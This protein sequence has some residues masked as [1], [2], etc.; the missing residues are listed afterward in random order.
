[1]KQNCKIEVTKLKSDIPNTGQLKY[2]D[3]V[4]PLKTIKKKNK[5]KLA[6][7]S[8]FAVALTL[9]LTVFCLSNFKGFSKLFPDPNFK[10][11]EIGPVD[12]NHVLNEV[13]RI[14]TDKW[15][16]SDE[17][18]VSDIHFTLEMDGF[19]NNFIGGGGSVM[20]LYDPKTHS[21]FEIHIA[22]FVNKNKLLIQVSKY[23]IDNTLIYMNKTTL[24]KAKRLFKDFWVE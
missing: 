21:V 23:K 22:N 9:I 16:L 7:T 1:M 19:I 14:V 10:N 6:I 12:V 11:T 24:E 4:N 2:R 8:I 15:N 17:T 18:V 20:N 5:I 13:E 3:E